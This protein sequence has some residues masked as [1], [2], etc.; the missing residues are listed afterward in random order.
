MAASEGLTHPLPS[1]RP[2]YPVPLSSKS[3]LKTPHLNSA[4]AN[5]PVRGVSKSAVSARAKG[6][7]RNKIATIDDLVAKSWTVYVS[8][9]IF[10]GSHSAPRLSASLRDH[11]KE[12]K[13]ALKHKT[14]TGGSQMDPEAVTHVGV[15]FMREVQGEV[16]HSLAINIESR[17]K[18]AGVLRNQVTQVMMYNPPEDLRNDYEGGFP[19]VL[20]KGSSAVVTSVLKWVSEF[21]DCF[22]RRLAIPPHKMGGLLQYFL[23]LAPSPDSGGRVTVD[24]EPSGVTAAHVSTVSCSFPSS[25]IPSACLRGA[26][27]AVG[28]AFSHDDAASGAMLMWLEGVVQTSAGIALQKC[29]VVGFSCGICSVTSTGVAK[30]SSSHGPTIKFVLHALCINAHTCIE[31]P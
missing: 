26:K 11:F 3:F 24:L 29:N 9:P 23:A 20:V 5:A 28:A 18:I 16:G 30:L 12:T 31:Q 13:G 14:A 4:A 17:M 22:I 15:E 1:V 19:L 27:G 2:H 8:S 7:S 21:F 10:V 25:A 6:S